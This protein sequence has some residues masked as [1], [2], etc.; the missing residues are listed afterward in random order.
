MF[1]SLA[2][3]AAQVADS[4]TSQIAS[5]A[6]ELHSHVTN[7][8]QKNEKREELSLERFRRGQDETREWRSGLGNRLDSQDR[9][10]RTLKATLRT[11]IYLLIT[12][13]GAVVAA[14]LHTIGFIK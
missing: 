2:K 9:E 10:M 14:L 8:D 1:G 6:A 11:A 7:C 3:H 12:T 5:I 4:A 13:L